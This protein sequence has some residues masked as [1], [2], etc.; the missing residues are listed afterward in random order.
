[1][2]LLREHLRLHGINAVLLIA[3]FV[4]ISATMPAFPLQ[5]PLALAGFVVLGIATNLFVIPRGTSLLSLSD[6]VFFATSIVLGPSAAAI[7]GIASVTAGT[8]NLGRGTAP[9]RRLSQ[10]IGNWGMYML[11]IVATTWAYQKL[12]GRLPIE[13]LTLQNYWACLGGILAYQIVNRGIMYTRMWLRGVLTRSELLAERED[14]PIELLSLHVGIPIALLYTSNGFGPLIFLGAFILFVSIVLR[15]RVAM[16][17]QLERQVAQLSAL[18]E[19]GRA[20]SA[21]L[22]IPRLTEAIYHESGKVIDTT[23]FYIALYEAEADEVTFILT[24]LGGKPDTAPTKRKGGKGLTEY[25][26]RTR[27]PLLLP[28]NVIERARALGMEPGGR[29]SQCWVGVPM[30]ASDRVIGMI[31]AQSYEKPNVFTNEHVDILSTIAAQAAIA[32]EN[33]RLLEAVAQQERLR[34]ELALARKIQQSLLPEPP[35]I[36]G[37]FIEGRCLQAA[38][39]GGDLFDFIL[40]DEHHLGIAIGDVTGKGMPAALLMATVRSVLRAQAQSRSDPAEVLRVVNRVMYGDTRG[41]SFVTLAYGVLDTRTWTFTFAIAGHLS[42][43][44]CGEQ[45]E[46]VYLVDSARL[47]LG[48]QA[49]MEYSNHRQ[50]LQPGQVIVLYT[51]GV[52][53]ARDPHAQM[54]G[55]ERLQ[56]IVAHQPGERLIDTILERTTQFT[57]PLALEDDLTLVVIQ[58]ANHVG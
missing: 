12:G 6:A 31:A 18:N 43:L 11:M 20:I 21:N 53:E 41:K 29:P 33:A 14:M 27:Q 28:D 9:A 39:T 4:A 17:Q 2:S 45:G 44:L 35:Q 48:S 7:V 38:E 10:M 51:D 13:R 49:E 54:L 57:G 1:M 55:F 19:V 37:L 34:Q 50:T 23:N 16:A 47:P 3:G 24:V 36:P 26:I 58:R 42:P 8:V 22:D 52:I 30:L 46:P 25:V 32:I 15:R 40:I 5:E 56:E